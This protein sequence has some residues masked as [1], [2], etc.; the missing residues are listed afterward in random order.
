M[1][2]LIRPRVLDIGCNR[3]AQLHWIARTLPRSLCLGLDALP[4]AITEARG[5][6]NLPN[7]TFEL[8]DLTN[9]NPAVRRFDM[10][11]AYGMLSWLPDPAREALLRLVAHALAPGGIALICWAA[12]PGCAATEAIGQLLRL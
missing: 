4:A 5:R 12:L 3:D 6:D 1:C 7:L 9:W 2:C 10:V 11:I 8:G